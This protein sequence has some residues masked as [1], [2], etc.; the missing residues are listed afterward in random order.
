M[1]NTKLKQNIL[2]V[3]DETQINRVLTSS[4]STHGYGVRTVSV[5]PTSTVAQFADSFEQSRAFPSSN[6]G[7]VLF[8]VGD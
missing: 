8:A 3:D 7:L 5:C 6:D 1:P 4:L 2:V